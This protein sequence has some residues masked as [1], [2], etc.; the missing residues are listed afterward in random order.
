MLGRAQLGGG[1]L[2]SHLAGA[3][4]C[5]GSALQ[6]A[7]GNAG[8]G[9]SPP[10]RRPRRSPPAPRPLRRVAHRAPSERASEHAPPTPSRGKLQLIRFFAALFSD[11][12]LL[13][14]VL[15]GRVG[16]RKANTK[17]SRRWGGG[18]QGAAQAPGPPRPHPTRS[19]PR[20]CAGRRPAWPGWA[21][22]C[23]TG[24]H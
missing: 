1:R 17:P 5:R 14:L 21:V 15:E 18:E 6:F 19:R 11:V 8:Y 3:Q 16:S 9:A 4:A 22:S 13:C 12:F 20:R 23:C 7:G 10:G 24:T 2:G